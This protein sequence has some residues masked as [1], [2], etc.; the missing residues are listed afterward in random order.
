MVLPALEGSLLCLFAAS[1][2]PHF[3]FIPQCNKMP[4][5]KG[6]LPPQHGL[7]LLTVHAW[8]QGGRDPQFNMAQGFRTVLELVSRYRELCVYWTVNYDNRD[9]T[10]RDFLS[11]Q[12]QKPRFWPTLSVAVSQIWGPSPFP[13][14]QGT[15]QG[16]QT[17]LPG[18]E[19]LS[20]RDSLST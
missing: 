15:E 13:L 3:P 9:K 16:Q 2:N 8:E 6:S 5:G 18:T 17:P 10:V 14:P 19:L 1:V 4:K 7:E 12:L 20:N 11:Q